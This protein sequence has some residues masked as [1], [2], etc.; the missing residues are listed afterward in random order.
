MMAK[1]SGSQ[2]GKH[3]R[4]KPLS[5]EEEA[6]FS[7]RV[8]SLT[9]RIW[10]LALDLEW[11]ERVRRLLLP[12][13]VSDEREHLEIQT[14]L[15]QK[16]LKVKA[17][18][19]LIKWADADFTLLAEVMRELH[20]D[21]GT[22]LRSLYDDLVQ[23]RNV[24]ITR[25]VGLVFTVARRYSII[26]KQSLTLEDLVQ[27]GMLGLY[28]AISRYDSLRGFKFSTFATW[29]I[30][31]AVLRAV[32]N[33]DR[34]VRIPVHQLEKHKCREADGVKLTTPVSIDASMDREDDKLSL[35]NVLVAPIEA[36][37]DVLYA[38]E[39]NARM[40]RVMNEVLTD[41]ERGII[42]RRYGLGDF[43][44][45]GPRTLEQ[46]GEDY[47]LTRERIRQIEVKALLAMR[48]RMSQQ[49]LVARARPF[50]PPSL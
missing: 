13:F 34:V 17:F 6:H 5:S 44:S 18:V 22:Y 16:R 30:R 12:H 20:D 24:F 49:E 35:Y 14:A 39:M 10:T 1:Q 36:P 7:A 21:C 31:H 4:S 33:K 27:E 43:R 25:N 48:Q 19:P 41:K 2:N 3:K 28:K 9:T 38:G 42:H 15:V 50:V 29:W 40:E 37:D 47:G 23:A 8:S 32:Q 26:A 45:V 46:V 11:R